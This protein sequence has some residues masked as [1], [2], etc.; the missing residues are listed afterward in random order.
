MHKRLLLDAQA[1]E[2]IREAGFEPGSI[3]TTADA[4]HFRLGYGYIATTA[5]GNRRQHYVSVEITWDQYRELDESVR[6]SVIEQVRTALRSL[7]QRP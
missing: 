6:K 1:A 2:A 5:S 7:A 4:E 3:H